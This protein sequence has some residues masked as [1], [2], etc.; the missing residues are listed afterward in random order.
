[1]NTFDFINDKIETNQKLN[2]SEKKLVPILDEM[3]RHYEKI[4]HN[5]ITN[6]INVDNKT[7]SEINDLITL[8]KTIS[9]NARQGKFKIKVF[10]DFK[11]YILV[12]KDLNKNAITTSFSLKSIEKIKKWATKKIKKDM[13]VPDGVYNYFI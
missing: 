4:I 10:L 1:M 11:N 9:Y 5:V 2:S 3:T 8:K 12:I 7:S 6:N 13:I